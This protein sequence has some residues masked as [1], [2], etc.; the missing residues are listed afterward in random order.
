[1]NGKVI[2][3]ALVLMV[4]TLVAGFMLGLVHEVTLEPIDR[5]NENIRQNAFKEVF[6]DADSFV[7]YAGFDAN[8]ANEIAKTTAG[9]EKEEITAAMEAKD[10]S[11]NTIGYVISLVT[12]GYNGAIE[13][14]VG[15]SND[16]TINGYK[17][18]SSGETP[19]LGKKA[20]EPKFKDQFNGKQT[21]PYLEV[22]KNNPAA[23]NPVEAISGAT[24][25]SSAVTRAVNA[26]ITYFKSLGGAN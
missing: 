15:I 16:G 5:A 23:G 3:D 2:K 6:A 8:Q 11:G 7:D 9:Y 4:I 17:I 12:Y 13:L 26:G 10:A 21:D 14:S 25:T 18:T 20:E 1:M 24:I 19:G 22:T